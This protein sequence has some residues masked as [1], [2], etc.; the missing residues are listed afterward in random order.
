VTTDFAMVSAA[1]AVTLPALHAIT[2]SIGHRIG[3]YNVVD[4]A[5]GLGFFIVA[6]V[7][8]QQRTSFFIP[9]R[10]GSARL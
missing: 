4:V 8:A 1:S 9:R 5:R 10:P 6:T 2:F 3:R 7:G